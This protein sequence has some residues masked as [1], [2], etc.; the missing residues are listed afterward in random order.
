MGSRQ[1]SRPISFIFNAKS[2]YAKKLCKL[3]FINISNILTNISD[4]KLNGKSK[5]I[6]YIGAR[7]RSSGINI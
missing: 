2:N 7:R 5:I 6:K 1:R 4:V 3:N